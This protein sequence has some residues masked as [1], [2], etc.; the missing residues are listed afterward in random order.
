MRL[1]AALCTLLTLAAAGF[2][3]QT[4]WQ[5]VNAPAADAQPAAMRAGTDSA[6]PPAPPRALRHWPPVFGEPQ[7]PAPV[8]QPKQAAAE[9]QPPKQPKPPLSSLGY[10]LKGVVRAGAETWAVLSHPTGERLL[11]KGEALDGGIVVAKIDET[12][13]WLSRDGDAAEL[14]AFPE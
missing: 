4:L 9:P 1:I 6:A 11:R 3:G 12:G 5:E 13:I 10:T 14:L 8:Q 7:P 2:A